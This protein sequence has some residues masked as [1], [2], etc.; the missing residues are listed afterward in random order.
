MR[1]PSPL[2]CLQTHDGTFRV[3]PYE[4]AGLEP[5]KLAVTA[6]NPLVTV[7]IRSAAVHA[8]LMECLS[9]DKTDC[10]YVDT[11]TRIQVLDTMVL[12]PQAEKKQSAA[13][14]MSTRSCPSSAHT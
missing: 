1:K 2:A 8:A 10:I 7:K 3:F 13:F 11:D 5:F 12:L 9:N 4:L 14:I 6:L